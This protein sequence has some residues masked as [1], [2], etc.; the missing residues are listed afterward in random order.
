LGS[1]TPLSVS[2]DRLRRIKTRSR[3]FN[4]CFA[5]VFDRDCFGKELLL[6]APA[7]GAPPRGAAADIEPTAVAPADASDFFLTRRMVTST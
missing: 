5:L 1:E 6:P 2:V 4:F 3:S 7:R